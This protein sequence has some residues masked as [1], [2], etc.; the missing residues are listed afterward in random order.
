MALVIQHGLLSSAALNSDLVDFRKKRENSVHFSGQECRP[1]R[2]SSLFSIYVQV[3]KLV[4]FESPLP[5]H[6]F[7]KLADLLTH[8]RALNGVP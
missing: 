6:V 5:L 8:R 1:K 3:P 4:T 7:N 2:R